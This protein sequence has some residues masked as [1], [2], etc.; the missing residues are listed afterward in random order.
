MSEFEILR[1]K[2]HKPAFNDYAL[3]MTTLFDCFLYSDIDDFASF[4]LD[5]GRITEDRWVGLY[6]NNHPGNPIDLVNH[7]ST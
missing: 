7:G 5:E 6:G 3:R 4:E 1:G 2:F